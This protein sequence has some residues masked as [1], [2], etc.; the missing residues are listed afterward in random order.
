MYRNKGFLSSCFF[1][2]LF[3]VAVLSFAAY[4]DSQNEQSFKNDGYIL[5]S[6][7]GTGTEDVNNQIYFEKGTKYKVKYPNKVVFTDQQ[8]EEVAIDADT[9]VHYNDGSVGTLADSVMMG[10]DELETSMVKYYGMTNESIIEN[11]GSNYILDNLG[12]PIDFKDLMWKISDNKY[13]IISDNIK[14]TFSNKNVKEFK[15]FVEINYY[16]YG[17]IRIITQ[18]GTW[19]TVSLNCYAEINN[20]VIINLAS[21]TLVKDGKAKMSME[22][23]VINSEDNI[24]IIPEDQK[25]LLAQVPKFDI[26]TIDGVNGTNGEK[27]KDGKIG[28]KG[29]EG[30]E[31]LK[32]EDGKSGD[33]GDSGTDGTAGEPGKPGTTGTTGANGINGVNGSNGS[34]GAN[35]SSGVNGASGS[36][37]RSGD[38]IELENSG[39]TELT[40]GI[41]LPVFTISNLDV[42]SNTMTCHI[43]VV[44]AENRLDPDPSKRFSIQILENSS[45]KQIYRK[46]DVDS[47][48]TS[49]NEYDF[50]FSGLIPNTEY[51]M[52]I[53]A[54]YSVDNTWYS[55]VFTDKFFKTDSLGITVKKDFATSDKLQFKVTIKEYSYLH[56]LELML[57]GSSISIAPKLVEGATAITQPDGTKAV[58]VTFEGLS[59]NTKYQLVAQNIKLKYDVDLVTAPDNIEGEFWTLRKAPQL[60]KPTVVVNKRTRS[61]EM[62][63]DS[64]TDSDNSIIRYRYEVYEV[65]TPDKLVKKLYTPSYKE[66]VVLY[67]DGV[68]I[69]SGQDYRVKVIAEG[70]DNEKQ[71]EYASAVSDVFNIVGSNYP[72]VTFRK[73]DV[74]TAHDRI[75]GFIHLNTNGSLIKVDG[76]NPLIIEYQ[77]SKGDINSYQIIDI[78]KYKIVDT[79]GTNTYDI[80]FYESDLKANDNYIINVYGNIDLNDG[81]GYT[82]RSLIGSIVTKTNT[83]NT[84][85]ANMTPEI[86]STNPIAFRLN[87]VDG[88]A[89]V[90]SAYEAST[91]EYVE[92][93]LYNGDANAAKTSRPVATYTLVGTDGENYNS[94]LAD[95]LYNTGNST[96]ITGTDFKINP[97]VISASKYTVEIISARDYT[98][99]G[100]EFKITDNIKTFDK[101]A[102]LPDLTQ[103]DVN[104]GLTILPITVANIS[105][106]VTDATQL[107]AYSKFDAGI[108]LG[109]EIRAAQFDNSSD[110]TESFTYYAF[111]Q[112][113]Y[114]QQ[115]TA[116]DFYSQNTPVATVVSPIKQSDMGAVPSAIFLFG[117]NEAASMTRGTKYVFTY[118]AKL[119]ET[120]DFFP[121]IVDPKV[122]IRSTTCDAPYQAPKVYFY[123]WTSDTQSVSWRYY[124]DTPDTAAV[125]GTFYTTGVG[126]FSIENNIPALNAQNSILKINSLDRGERYSLKLMTRSYSNAFYGGAVENTLINQYFE[127]TYVLDKDTTSLSFTMTDNPLENRYLISVSDTDNVNYAHI[128]RLAALK[129]NVYTNKTDAPVKS[130]IIPFDSLV[131]NLGVAYLKYSDIESLLNRTLYFS[132]SAIYDNGVSGFESVTNGLQFALQ[133][134]SGTGKGNYISINYTG[135]GIAEDTTG[136]AKGSFFKVTGNNIQPLNTTIDFESG[137]VN[138]YRDRFSFSASSNGARLSN[139]NLSPV[140]TVKKLDEVQLKKTTYPV[141]EDP[142]FYS[143]NFNNITPAV[144]LNSGAAYTID[145]TVN[146]A[147][148]RWTIAGHASK[149]ADSAT[150]KITPPVMYFDLYKIDA[151]N[152]QTY[153]KTVQTTISAIT[154][155]YNTFIEDLQPNTKYGVKLYFYYNNQP[156]VKIYPIN[157]YRP[158]VVPTSNNIYVFTTADKVIITPNNPAITYGATSYLDK[159]LNLSYGL[160]LTLGFNIQYSICKKVGQTYQEV[161]SSS[162]LSSLGVISTPSTYN[163]NMTNEKIMLTPGRLKWNENGST[164]YF[165][166]NND[167]YYICIRPVSRTN[168]N[169]SLGDSQ[170]VSLKVP[171]LNTP[172]YNIKAVPGNGTVSFNI[173]VSDSDRVMVNEHYKIRVVNQDGGEIT[174]DEYKDV[175]YST[176]LPV[177]VNVDKLGTTGSAILKLYSVYD[178]KNTRLAE[179]GSALPDIQDVAYSNLD[180][181]AND[182]LKATNTGYPLGNK[183][184]DLGTVQIAQSSADLARIYFINAVNLEKVKYIQYVIINGQ[185]TS[186]SYSD[187]FSPVTASPTTQYYELAHRF[188]VNG[189]YQVQIRFYDSNMNK[190]DDRILTLFKNV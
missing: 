57:T 134:V 122:V 14:I 62:H 3:L 32:G 163:V 30:L 6:P 112:A 48:Q 96:L 86:A 105:Q 10:L 167:N 76:A 178:V 126:T 37:G 21:R 44:D 114:S 144:N 125:V 174:P 39:G 22:Q 145:T 177:V 72:T 5:T 33:D 180:N 58:T 64:V 35:G 156:G 106:Y 67:V 189:T 56:S 92:I 71:T 47:I 49:L 27:G 69:R 113:S 80:P 61:F 23:M 173:S 111:D 150:I 7:K 75:V 162:E 175:T 93:N 130:I 59:S 129:V 104:N 135:N 154:S 60:G 18:E 43:S 100:N 12:E 179:D 91:M 188:T 1:V 169:L 63:L 190:L 68:D 108:I 142:V 138:T 65:G 53:S 81:V 77:N 31:G 131:Q 160:N 79:S 36:N 133:T 95:Q 29:K 42:K 127:S 15:D 90:S 25:K 159:Y 99:Y 13:M 170:Y 116:Q 26:K 136:N 157:S 143:F 141:N 107:Q 51:R 166:F 73:D 161:V 40:K 117:K 94:T 147:N 152:F 83:P 41:I 118:R 128:S 28:D 132:I 20:G 50:S 110:L 82:K 165:S 181:A 148:I 66:P 17:I 87:L 153:V 182:Y 139:I 9:F 123:P 158:E 171:A 55:K 34:S 176:K 146:S 101:R 8:G 84:F 124:I 168:P 183:D 38:Q 70:F 98:K 11:S 78:S 140:T 89:G 120:S 184:Y 88:V 97:S 121:E 185:G 109:Y 119:K 16:D 4:K 149:M 74:L 115:P 172:F 19:Q 151:Q 102:T 2:L 187:P 46:D 137:I 24:Q 85:T 54:N 52:V 103:I 164:V 186:T 155:S 45:G